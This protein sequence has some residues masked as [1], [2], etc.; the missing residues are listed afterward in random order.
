[1]TRSPQ[2]DEGLLTGAVGLSALGDFLAL[3]PLALAL[4]HQTNSGLV[5][6]GLFVALWSP[7]IL[8][9][10]LA[11]LLVDKTDPRRVLAAASVAQAATAV[12]LAF[13]ADTP[14]AILGLTVVLG[15]GNAFSQP[16]E[17]A[18]APRLTRKE[19]VVRLNARLETARY[20]G[21]A[22]GP[23]LGGVLAAGGGTQ[24]ALLVDAA[25]FVVIAAV[26][27]VLRTER[28]RPAQA[29]HERARDGIAFLT[30]DEVLRSVLPVAIVALLF[31]TATATAEVFFASDVLHAG[32]AGYGV[33]VTAWFAG[34][35]LGALLIAPRME[36]HH[37]A[38][39]ALLAIAV[40]GVGIALPA[41]WPVFAFVVAVYVA[42]GAAHGVKNVVLRTLIHE[43]T[44]ARLHGR[45]FAAYNAMRNAAELSALTGG[46]LLVAT[47]GPR[48]T[49][50]I[51]G[52]VPVLAT[53]FAAAR[54]RLVT[55][56][57]PE[58]S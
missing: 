46:G 27:S 34:M 38:T 47:I 44:P 9:A 24:A 42:G 5:V 36:P 40:Q 43:R 52:G 11:G 25:T 53:A 14:A 31:M 15:I 13:A 10:G 22:I 18:L 29:A 12:G 17:F 57:A 50:A 6:A 49:L 8:L 28:L 56:P 1:M 41:A 2:R 19:R 58:L 20:A 21:L 51:A 16:A 26:A 48:A 33:L 7:S 23:L 32:D 45:A 37:A 55:R 39:V 3:I 54:T 35:V 4:E 30:K